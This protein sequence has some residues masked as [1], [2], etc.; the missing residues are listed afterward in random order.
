MLLRSPAEEVLY[1]LT[2]D[3][4]SLPCSSHLHTSACLIRCLCAGFISGTASNHPD[5]RQIRKEEMVW[6]TIPGYRPPSKGKAKVGTQAVSH[7]MSHLQ[8]RAERNIWIHASCFPLSSFLLFCIK[9]WTLLSGWSTTM[10]GSSYISW[11]SN[12]PPPH[13]DMSADQAG[14]DNSGQS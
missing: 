4:P 10:A 8:S 7:V 13:A 1:V 3:S 12:T 2:I 11:Q 5:L 9:I 6:F 14:L